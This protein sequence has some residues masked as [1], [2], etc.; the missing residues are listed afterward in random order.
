MCLGLD[1]RT[2]PHKSWAFTNLESLDRSLGP[3]YLILA[4]C[5]GSGAFSNAVTCPWHIRMCLELCWLT[6]ME[7]DENVMMMVLKVVFMAV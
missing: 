1:R 5:P 4:C 2:R 7:E 6:E 3:L